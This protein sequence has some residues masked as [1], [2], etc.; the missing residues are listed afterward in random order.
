M[1][2]FVNKALLLLT[3]LLISLPTWAAWTAGA[4]AISKSFSDS[5]RSQHSLNFPNGPMK[6]SV[7]LFGLG[8]VDLMTLNMTGGYD[9]GYDVNAGI[10]FGEGV[11]DQ[12]G[13][14]PQLMTRTD[15][16]FSAAAWAQY[17]APGLALNCWGLTSPL[18]VDV[19][20][21]LNL[22]TGTNVPSEFSF[23]A[24][25]PSVNFSLPFLDDGVPLATIPLN[26]IG[27][28]KKDSKGNSDHS[29]AIS[30]DINRIAA[31]RNIFSGQ[32]GAAIGFRG[33]IDL[34]LAGIDYHSGTT[35]LG[36]QTSAATGVNVS[37]YA[38]GT[39]NVSSRDYRF[40][41]R[42]QVT[43][44]VSPFVKLNLLGFSLVQPYQKYFE[45]SAKSPALLDATLT[46]Q[47]EFPLTVS[48]FTGNYA[49]PITVATS[50]LPVST[51]TV[52]ALA[53]PVIASVSPAS[54]NGVALPA[55][56][57]L[58]ISGS[59][60]TPSSKL[61]FSSATTN[62][63][64]QTPIYIS[65]TLLKYN[66]AAGSVGQ[67][68]SVKVIEGGA[69]SNAMTFAVAQSADTIA[70]TVTI[71]APTTATTYTTT[72][73]S[74][75]LN[76]GVSD[77]VGVTSVTWR[78]S[79]G[80]SG[81]AFI[82]GDF[83]T[84]PAVQLATG[85]NILTIGAFDA[86][87]NSSLATVAI[88]VSG[89]PSV[90]GAPGAPTI[91]TTT[92]S[93][94]QANV[95]FIAPVNDG[96]TPIS[97]Y[98]VTSSPGGLTA[99]GPA[100]PVI[101]KGLTTG[102]PYTFTVTATNSTG[103]SVASAA[104]N[105]VTPGMGIQTVSLGAF[106]GVF[107]LN[108]AATSQWHAVNV[109][110]EGK[111]DI[112]INYDATLANGSSS[113]ITL[114]RTDGTTLLAS[115]NLT[116]SGTASLTATHLAAGTY[117]I[118]VYDSYPAALYG[119]Y[120]LQANF[121]PVVVGATEIES[122]DTVATANLLGNPSVGTLGY[123]DGA[124][125][126]DF[127][128]YYKY[129]VS[130]DGT[131]VVSINYDAT[132]ANGSSSTITLYRTDGTTLL[133]SANLTASGTA[134]LTATHL[135]AGTYYIKVYDSYPAALYGA[136]SLQANFTPV[137][138]GATEIESN[139]TVATANLL[140][141]PSVG[142]LGYY[143][144][145]G[146]VDF[147]DYYKYVVS[148]DGTLVVSIN[149]D[150]TLANGSSS[151]ITLYR[152]DGT[153]EISSAGLQT[154]GTASLTATH[155]AAGTY[156]IKV[157]DSYPA[158]LYGA[159]S[160]QANFTPV[161][162]GATEIESNDTVATANLLGNPSVGTLG[163]YD[164]AGRV[165]FT[166]YYKYVVSQDG[167]LVVSINYDATLAN[168]SSSTIT[169]YRTDGTTLLASANLTASG[170]ASLTA[171]H[172]AAGTYYIK[173][174]DSYPAA[175]YGA[176]RIQATFTT[177]Q[178]AYVANNGSNTLSSYAINPINGA[179]TAAGLP[180]ASGIN[181]S[182]VTV[183]PTGKF[184]YVAGSNSNTLSPY[185]INQTTGALNAGTPVA[186]DLFPDSVTI[187]PSG[188]YAY[189][190][191]SNSNTITAYAIDPLTGA[192]TAGTTAST[193]SYPV[194][195]AVDPSGKF[196][197]VANQNSNNVSVYSINQTTGALTAGTLVVAGVQPTMVTVDPTGKF[198]FVANF[199][200]N[201]V[202]VYTIG[203]VT[204]ALTIGTAAVTGIGPDAIAIDPAGKF[205][206][207][208][209]QG[210]NTVSVYAVDA[211]TGALTG[212][213]TV[214]TGAGPSS[215]SID[216]T[217]KFAYVANKAANTI[218]VYTINALTGAL[219]AGTT[220]AAGTQPIS[221]T[222]TG[223]MV[224][225]VVAIPDAP[226]IGAATA[227]NG[228]ATVSFTTP[229]SNGGALITGY[230]VTSSP[231][232][233]AAT[234]IASPLTVT[235]L[236]NGTAYTF[237]VTASNSAGAGPSS[238]VSNTVTPIKANQTL[239]FGVAPAIALYG[240]GN[241]SAT[242]TSGLPVTFSS[243]TPSICTLNGSVV[244]SITVGICI[245]AADQ[246]GN[247]SFNV[248]TRVT[249]P[250]LIAGVI[251]QNLSFGVVPVVVVHGTGNVSA[252]ATSGLP[253]TFSSTTPTICSVSGNTVT[254]IAVGTCSIAANQSGNASYNPAAQIVQ[255]ITIGAG[256]GIAVVPVNV[257]V[258]AGNGQ[259]TLNWTASAGATS[260]KVY[261]SAV[262]GFTTSTAQGSVAGILGTSAVIA[263]LTNGTKYYFLVTA[264]N[265]VGESTANVNTILLADDAE[266][267]TGLWRADSPWGITNAA[268]HSGVSSYTDSP[269]GDYANNANPAL[270]LATPLDL[271]LA[272]NPQLTFW[273][274]HVLEDTYDFGLVEVST[275][276]GVVWNQLASFT[277][278]QAT[279]SQVS[280]N[281]SAYIGQPSVK[282]RFRLH[283][284]ASVVYDG[285]YLDDIIVSGVAAQVAAIPKANQ[286][287]IFGA[288]PALVAGGTATAS[289]TA[290]SALAVSFT[291]I[292]PGVC[293][294]T[295]NI[296]TG[297][298]PGD[299]TIAAVQSGNSSVNPAPQVAQSIVIGMANQSVSFGAAP[300]VVVGGTGSVSVTATSALIVGLRSSTPS[301]CT[302]TGSTVSG[303]AAGTCTIVANQA[304]D[305]MHNAAIQVTQNISI[306]A[307]GQTIIFGAAPVI[308]V[309]GTGSVT[310]TG[311]ASG[312]AVVFSSTT[313]TFCTLSGSLVTGVASGVCTIAANQS[314]NANFNPAA[315][316]TQSITVSAAAQS[317]VFAVPPV[318]TVGGTGVV[319]ATG[320]ASGNAVIFSSTTPSICSVTGSNV[321]GLVAGTCTIAANQSGN[322]SYNAAAQVTQNINVTFNAVRRDF[323]GDGKS[324]I[325]WR[326][327]AGEVAVWLMNGS[328]LQSSGVAGII[329]ANWQLAGT[330][331]FNG[332][333]RADIVR[334][335]PNGEV[336]IWIMNG[337]VIQ[338]SG[339]VTT[340]PLGWN[341]ASVDDFNGDGKADLLW[342]GPAGEVAVWL[343][344]GS[345]IQ[346]SSI[347]STL[348]AAWVIAESGDFNGD[349]KADIL[350]HNTVSGENSVWLMNGAALLSSAYLN[351]LNTP[352]LIAGTGDF[353]GDG[354]TDILWRNTTT[355]A[356]AVWL[357]NG[358]SISSS[359]YLNTLA[360]T[361]SVSAVG[362][363]NGDGKA[364]ILWRNA[365]AGENAIWLINGLSVSSS[366][367]L[368]VVPA[369]WT[370]AAQSQ[371]AAAPVASLSTA[372]L[373]FAAQHTGTTS[374]AQL[375]TL[376]NTGS[377]VLN[378]ASITA[379]AEY[380]STTTCGATLA[381]GANCTFSVSFTPLAPGLRN[382]AVTVTSDASAASVTLSGT[383][384]A[385]V[386]SDFNGDSNSDILLR[387]AS[388]GQNVIWLMNGTTMSSSGYINS[389]AAP[390]NIAAN[391][392]FDGDGKADILWR[393]PVSG[394]DAIWFMNG[395]AQT[396]GGYTL[397]VAAPWNIIG[398][399]DFDGDG[400][401]DLLWRDATSGANAVWLMNGLTQRSGAS[402]SGIA[403]PWAL[404]ALADF[405][406][407]GKADILWRNGSTGQNALW[408][409]NGTAMLSSTAV[410][411]LAAPWS[412]A[413]T[414][415][416][417]GD[418]KADLLWRNTVTGQNA[419]WYMNGAVQTSGAYLNSVPVNWNVEK[420]ADYN[421]DGKADLLWR[422]SVSGMTAVW[423]MN[424]AVLNSSGVINS[425]LPA[426]WGVAK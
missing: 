96:G 220:V 240:T 373:S 397:T 271:T 251:N 160:L 318:V 228:Q 185:T 223:R 326:G 233:M 216:S 152:T 374:A 273:H 302:V 230:T 50:A 235:G 159:Y 351:T 332:D 342:R 193:G 369:S 130:Q 269:V 88:T 236:T 312:S 355:G 72:L 417:D 112:L 177:N 202:S 141:N 400:K 55:T 252:T 241:V 379:S 357:M 393:D 46:L 284:D 192:L 84:I 167:T 184:I 291:S 190:V 257:T 64:N 61:D 325:L 375:V 117:Y 80:G 278:T 293:S 337:S 27:I 28:Y 248:A 244:T 32:V 36:S 378:I 104:S 105:Q 303:A 226:V 361:W 49:V 33:K 191:N 125:R 12:P 120:S 107:A 296:I 83:W 289:A 136:Y 353:N 319:S 281:L 166:D 180:I 279:W 275:D 258:A 367:Y 407:D 37:Q 211:L 22:A 229:P 320:G 171:T 62:L 142:T 79:L 324:D 133:A 338:S 94:T 138:V 298:T 179:L 77:N 389:V 40:A 344:N 48:S 224:P 225:V 98:T 307:G 321:S 172:L 153:T 255:N 109:G 56:Q 422:D 181:P 206:Y 360:V 176:Y 82:S 2:S 347:V 266:S 388:T 313:P 23:R 143:D 217:G 309:G 365:A 352:W 415:D 51:Q 119:A 45:T 403:A 129:V 359:G 11:W 148:Q 274:K 301:I 203:A 231:G 232:G 348:P 334:R 295:G 81:S 339:S 110:L 38:G 256:S 194:S 155:L 270:T 111:L 314:G 14:V 346:S 405:N 333:G 13:S 53:A 121:T 317:L 285:W 261:W 210:G 213:T 387:N 259:V 102:T 199:G 196:V 157:Y 425:S 323:N 16:A 392:D 394:N 65:P 135:A 39:V 200:S 345:T 250:I 310:A 71:S 15:L 123:Y 288:A 390:W 366:A 331:D 144:G 24:E 322:A 282:I 74:I 207:V 243:T 418:G 21:V 147:T 356:N 386:S 63:S 60:F 17:Q 73:G 297:I 299:C 406:G 154:S 315:Q 300:T 416:F 253:V 197:Y 245:V 238:L 137:V 399:A 208:T 237:S 327:P 76:G 343:M 362:D 93:A 6:W 151:T 145:A 222:T 265:A 29:L 113:T 127:T 195:V 370:V 128:D 124:G 118:K 156:Y 31:L 58:T 10:N 424:G 131:L 47:K 158:A 219:T 391:G 308:A 57:L 41:A 330:G 101:V 26:P 412:I 287:V 92:A 25:A 311:G 413:G 371:T 182:S 239:N 398:A 215:I 247:A 280:I 420:V 183:D 188:K 409:M 34:G 414:G 7:Q 87:G 30:V 419:V 5:T 54:L 106:S 146:R 335:G 264:V 372:S 164:G 401:A 262:A 408:L 242:S 103:T 3:L 108:T 18:T 384:K 95:S 376:S 316:V 426:A 423:L 411:T 75:A 254:G 402:L 263:G 349:G 165:D 198:A 276:G 59:G 396:S 68:W 115:A 150:A 97:G 358:A 168:G 44:G 260:Y 67:S 201:T 162:V 78:N 174:Y 364:D 290:T 187:E 350:W 272:V 234:G 134:S 1:K 173:V 114:Y 4:N 140:G 163:Y 90:A 69:I 149:Y 161:V 306:G 268:S 292:T 139:D 410:S 132:L 214:A 249:Q 363:Y 178:Y 89:V 340:V 305:A 126:V 189:V 9:V 204:G 404:A 267:G 294:V 283:S 218:S 170:T 221:V 85:V 99:T 341:I 286:T 246:A 381:V 205:A 43:A 421:G 395:T 380:A 212:G 304:G 42:P 277:G 52:S 385:S 66:I 186:T 70:P 209:N 328:A 169:L 175:L 122:N 86:A 377:A 383:G 382:G 19:A 329:P 227:G 8:T 116:A 35:L 100:S 368:N 336:A 354:K 20:Q 91:G